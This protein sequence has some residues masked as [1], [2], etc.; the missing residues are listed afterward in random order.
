LAAVGLYGVLSYSV[1]Q[2]KREIGIRLALG[3]RPTAVVRAIVSDLLLL[4]SGGVVA[5]LGCGV[6]LARLVRTMLFEVTPYDVASVALPLAVLALV[7][8]AAAVPPAMRAARV[9][10]TEALRYE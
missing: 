8:I 2:R 4:T 7:A 1:V 10:P 5:G 3:A 9:D 6:V